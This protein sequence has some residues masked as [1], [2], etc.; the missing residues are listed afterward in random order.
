MNKFDDL[1]DI[2]KHKHCTYIMIVHDRETNQVHY[3]ANEDNGDT[4][5]HLLQGAI[6]RFGKKEEDAFKRDTGNA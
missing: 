5:G 2:I 6:Q 4:I 1:R 3:L